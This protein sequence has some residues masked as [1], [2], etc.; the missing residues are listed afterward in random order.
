MSPSPQ[1]RIQLLDQLLGLERHASAGER[2]YLIHETPDRFLSGD[3]VQRPRLSTTADLAR[4]QPKLPSSAL[5]LVPEKLEPLLDLH[6][7]R[8]LRMQLHPPC[9]ESEAPRPLPP[10]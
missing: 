8:L 7:P 4:R 5:D 10:A 2:A 3:S 6:D 1:Y 9:S